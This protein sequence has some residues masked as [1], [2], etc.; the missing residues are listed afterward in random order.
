M[1]PYQVCRGKHGC[2]FLRSFGM[3]KAYDST[4]ELGEHANGLQPDKADLLFVLEP[5]QQQ[6]FSA[7]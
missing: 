3:Q 1:Y 7:S 2:D 6:V 5:H 4:L